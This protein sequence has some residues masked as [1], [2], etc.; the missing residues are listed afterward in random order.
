MVK[1]VTSRFVASEVLEDEDGAQRV[2]EL[3]R[4]AKV[5][6]PFPVLLEVYYVSL[7]ECTEEVADQRYALLKQLPV[8]HLWEVDEPTLLTAARLEGH[9]S[10]SLAG[11]L[12]AA[13]A[14]RRGAILVHK[15]PEFEA[16][17]GVVRQE[18]LPYKTSP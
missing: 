2:E 5:I 13:F 16:A 9:H 7:R 15:D 4:S 3:L 10:L 18:A 1:N 17:V 12:I 14:L 6:L 11:A 8:E